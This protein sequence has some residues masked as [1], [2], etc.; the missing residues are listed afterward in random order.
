MDTLKI[1]ERHKQPIHSLYSSR[2]KI[3]ILLTLLHNKAS[4]S[5]LRE[6]T[7]STSQALIPKIRNLEKQGLIEAVNYEVLPYSAWGGGCREC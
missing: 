7:G 3:Q 1:Y 4:L 6:V 5:R 2:L